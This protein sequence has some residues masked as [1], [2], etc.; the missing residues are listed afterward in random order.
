MRAILAVLSA[1]AEAT[2]VIDLAIDVA[3]SVLASVIAVPEGGDARAR[4]AT[5]TGLFVRPTAENF[6]P[7]GDFG[8]ALS[9]EYLSRVQQ[10]GVARA[11][12]LR[13]VFEAA[14]AR[15]D[16]AHPESGRAGAIAMNWLEA[17]GSAAMMI[18]GVGRAFDLTVVTRPT[19]GAGADHEILLESA[20]FETG[21][22]V[23]VTP[24]G[25]QAKERLGGTVALAWNGSTETARA[26]AFAMPLVARADKV[27]VISVEGSLVPG[28]TGGDIVR[29]LGHHG[30]TAAARH[31]EPAGQ[32]AGEVFVGETQRLGCDWMIKG[33][34]T[35][36]RLRQMI[37]G[38]A[39]RHIL[40]TATM[41]V[42]MAH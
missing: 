22:P 39:T 9:Q 4:G 13:A 15:R 30:V 26:L 16:I 6:I 11:A 23:L 20:L 34:Y 14:A 10:D 19:Q 18:G 40:N 17:E 38:G 5:V 2:A 32:T 42:L 3:R 25:Y 27:Y 28:P 35:Q 36:S 8:L 41:P 31:I 37:F 29:Y 1:E 7:S 33:A 21:R 24:P 12:R